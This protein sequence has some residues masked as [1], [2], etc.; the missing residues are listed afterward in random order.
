MT[1]LDGLLSFGSFCTVQ[2]ESL[3]NFISS[4]LLPL[5]FLFWPAP[6]L[7][8]FLFLVCQF[9]GLV[10]PLT[11]PPPGARWAPTGWR[12]CSDPGPGW[13]AGS[14]SSCW[15]T[16]RLTPPAPEPLRSTP[17][18]PHLVAVEN[19]DTVRGHVVALRQ[20]NG[21]TLQEEAGKKMSKNGNSHTDTRRCPVQRGQTGCQK[22]P[23]CPSCDTNTDTQKE[24]AGLSGHRGGEDSST[25]CLT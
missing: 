3:I 12:R 20:L 5:W 10:S 4:Q 13:R 15:S 1:H 22:H 6:V 17:W 9:R 8:S 24:T 19:R 21:V 11:S 18:W 2:S 7:L 23:L 14:G 25:R 16:C